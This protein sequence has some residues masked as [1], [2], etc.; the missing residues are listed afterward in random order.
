[1]THKNSFIEKTILYT[2]SPIKNIKC[3]ITGVLFA[4]LVACQTQ[5]PPAP[6]AQNTAEPEPTAAPTQTDTPLPVVVLEP[7]TPTAIPTDVPVATA[8]ATATP[9]A[10][11]TAE[12]TST[13]VPP[14][15]VVEEGA[16]RP[17]SETANLKNPFVVADTLPPHAPS[18]FEINSGFSNGMN[19][20]HLG[21]DVEGSA[22]VLGP[23]LDV[24]DRRQVKA[25]MFL[26]GSWAVVYQDWVKVM[27]DRGHEFANH[28]WSHSN[29]AQMSADQVKQELADTEAYI[30]SLTGKST[31]P[32]MRPPFGSRSDISIQAA[33]EEGYSTII[34]TGSTEDWREDANANSMCKT[35][36]E[37]SFPGGILYSHTWH[38]DMPETIDRYIGEMLAQGYTFVPMSV[39][40]SDRPQDYLIPNN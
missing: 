23:L 8:E 10:T 35:L 30:V 39:I 25:T 40:M 17:L 20:I 26:L 2:S 21:F 11:Q 32:F 16:C 37:T 15:E 19:I 33:Y 14:T 5:A 9:E 12:P 1:M 22:E 28:T 29:M 3:L 31:K 4:A 7:A 18:A 13:K 27:A 6:T 34:W 36:L 24:L 38:P